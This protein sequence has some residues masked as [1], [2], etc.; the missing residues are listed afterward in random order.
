MSPIT[1][2]FDDSSPNFNY[3]GIWWTGGTWNAS[4]GDSGSLSG[5]NDLNGFAVFVS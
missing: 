4:D 2:A 5:T 3:H 1:Q